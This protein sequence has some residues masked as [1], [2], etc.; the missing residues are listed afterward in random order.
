MLTLGINYGS[1]DSAAAVARDGEILFATADERLSHK[2]HDGAFPLS[3]IRASLAHAGAE[4]ADLDEVA[5]GWQPAAA[6][7]SNDLRNYLTGAHPM[8]WR[9]ALKA[10]TIGRIEG[11]QKDGERLFRRHFGSPK[12]GFKRIDHH[13]AHAL[14]AYPVSGFD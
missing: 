6:S 4:L 8:G 3:A 11:Y 12:N 2:K 13:Y 1:H 14:S 10:Q 9:E 5:F 7:R